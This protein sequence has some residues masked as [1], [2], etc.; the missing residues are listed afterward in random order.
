MR[1]I[2]YIDF[3]K[4]YAIFTIVLYHAM[5]QLPL[6]PM[7]QKAIIFGGTGVHLFFLLS[8]FGL[9]L[10]KSAKSA[11]EFYRRRLVKIWLPYVLALTISLLAAFA[12]DLFADGLPA[13]AAGVLLYQMFFEKYVHSFGGHF[14]FI[15]AI[16]Q[17]YLAFPALA[18]LK[19]RLGHRWAFAAICLLASVAWWLLVFWLGKSHERIWNSCFLQFLWEFGLGMAFAD[20]FSAEN[21]GPT[22]QPSSVSQAFS[23]PQTAANW[24]EKAARYWC[25]SLP[26]GLFF[27]GV[28][29]AMILKMG[30]IGRL[31]NDIPALIGYAA[32]SVFAYQFGARAFPPLRQFFLWVSAFSYS[33]YL[34]HILTLLLWLQLL[35]GLGIATSP[36]T[37]APFVP[38][39]L[40]AG[41][42]F[43]PL[44]QWWVGLFSKR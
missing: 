9:G 25:A 11:G 13:W 32:L 21:A 15:S 42:A 30:D 12:L 38:L 31:F 26:I 8:G 6:A 24:Q 35:Q 14:W 16:V 41:W 39:A 20:V 27:T 36:L 44:S 40:A 17:F 10:S 22:A 43:E 19:N 34:V 2:E 3:A 28:M 33:L 7:L 23:A 4:G 37:L 1:K 29:V 18:W 5:Q